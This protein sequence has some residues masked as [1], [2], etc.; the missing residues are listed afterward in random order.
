MIKTKVI[1]KNITVTANTTT[2]FDDSFY[3]DQEILMDKIIYCDVTWSNSVNDV[4]ISII[5]YRLA[6]NNKISSIVHKWADT[7]TIKFKVQVVYFGV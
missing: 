2:I 3:T 6:L 1:S 5:K 7:Q 4:P